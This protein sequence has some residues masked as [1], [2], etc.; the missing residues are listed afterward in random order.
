M[1]DCHA[2][3]ADASFADDLDRVLQRAENLGLS[4]VICVSEGY[5][6][7]IKVIELGRSSPLIF[8][9]LG[10]HPEKADIEE[11]SRIIELIKLHEKA[12]VGIGEV[13]LDYWKAKTDDERE[14]QKEV[15]ASFI[16]LSNDLGL[17]LNVH[18]RSAGHH[19]LKLLREHGAMHVLM[20]AFDGKASHVDQ[21]LDAGY[22]FSIPPSAVRSDQKKKLIRR[23][24]LDAIL[25]ESDSPVLGPI[26]SVRNEPAN[27]LHAAKLIAEIKQVSCEKVLTITTENAAEFFSLPIHLG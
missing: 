21:G 18:S 8:P 26:P 9:C 14:T 11:S 4:A 22:R 6:D 25:L 24:P 3:L 7:S 23:L 15:L 20:H 5:E 19:T 10:L 2:H 17:P 1:I 12:I 27:I 16:S 13:G